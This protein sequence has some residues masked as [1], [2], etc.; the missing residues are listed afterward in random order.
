MPVAIHTLPVVL[1]G[2]RRLSIWRHHALLSSHHHRPRALLLSS[3]LPPRYFGYTTLRQNNR[4]SRSFQGVVLTRLGVA[5]ALAKRPYTKLQTKKQRLAF[6]LQFQFIFQKF[7]RRPGSSR[8]QS[9]R[10]DAR[11]SWASAGCSSA[12]CKSVDENHMLKEQPLLI[13]FSLSSFCLC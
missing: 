13:S 9:P 7:K 6:Q 8:W 5:S 10:F 1:L 11:K 2:P 4:R 12:S 3:T